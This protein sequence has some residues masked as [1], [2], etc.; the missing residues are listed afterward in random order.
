MDSKIFLSYNKKMPSKID[1][2]K[3]NNN[4]LLRK[5]A[6]KIETFAKKGYLHGID[7]KH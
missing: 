7:G 4:S 5:M 1:F 3:E 2:F 6:L